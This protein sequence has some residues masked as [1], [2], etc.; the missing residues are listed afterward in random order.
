MTRLTV[1]KMESTEPAIEVDGVSK[2]Y[3]QLKDT[4]MLLRSVMPFNRPK[5]DKLMALT[6]MNFSIDPGETVGILGRNGSGKSTLMRLMAGVT[7]PS[8]GV[9]RVRGRV[10]PLLSVGVGFHQEMSGRE[11]VYVNGM[12]MGLS[13]AEILEL[14]DEIVEFSEI[15]EFIDTPVKFYSSGMYMRLGFSVAAHISP[16]I[17]L[18]DEV[19]AVGDVAFQLKCFDRLRELQ[20]RGTTIVMV[21]HNMHAIRLLCPRVLLMRKGQLEYDGDSETAISRHIPFLT[22]DASEDHFGHS[23]MPVT[24]LGRTVRRDGVETSAASQHDTL[25]VTW[26]IQFETAIKSPQAVFRIIAEDGTLAYQFHTRFGLEWRDFSAGDT[27]EISVK[28][29][30]RF[31]GGGT[32]RLLLDVCDMTNAHLLGTDTEGPRIYVAGRVATSGLGD[33]VADISIA[34]QILTNWPD[35]MFGDS[36]PDTDPPSL[37]PPPG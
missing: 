3:I 30:P 6:D 35:Y 21:S 22:L 34:G 24:I 25:E 14:F 4:A 23:G 10:A 13:F 2:Q 36:T 27:T 28:F 20:R 9:V 8:A 37:T 26:K 32:F 19:L 33:A 16:Q 5:R 12:L 7:A 17:I 1:Q 29:Q 15:G 11:N 18:L 31:G